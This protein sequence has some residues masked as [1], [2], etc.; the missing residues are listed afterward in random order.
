M[1]VCYACSYCIHWRAIT[2]F[3]LSSI[4]APS[5]LLACSSWSDTWGE[6]GYIRIAR[7]GSTPAGEKCGTDTTPLDGDGCAGGPGAI[8]V[9]GEC[10]ILSDSSIPTGA[11]LV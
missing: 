3:R 4:P 5:L 9:C 10:A 11:R 6:G 7:Y 1:S 8:T 2:S